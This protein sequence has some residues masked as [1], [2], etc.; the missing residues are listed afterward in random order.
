MVVVIIYY[1]IIGCKYK[2]TTWYLNGFPN[3][4]NLGSKYNVGDESTVILYIY[5]NHHAKPPIITHGVP[6][7]APLPSPSL[8]PFGRVAARERQGVLLR[9]A[10]QCYIGWVRTRFGEGGGQLDR[11]RARGGLNPSARESQA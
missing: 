2:A 11:R 4:S 5:I 7:C 9:R 6:R 3:A 1:Y 10:W 8:V